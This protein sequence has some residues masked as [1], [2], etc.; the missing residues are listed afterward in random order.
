MRYIALI[1]L[2][3][4]SVAKAAPLLQNSDFASNA[5]IIS[6]GGTSS[7]LLNTAKIFDDVNS[8]LLDVT[9]AGLLKSP[10]NLV[11]QVNGVLRTVNGG[12][13][14][15]TTATNGQLLIGNGSGYTLATLIQGSGVTITNGAG[16]ITISASNASSGGTVT[17]VSVVN[18]GGISAVVTNPTTTPSI[19]LSASFSA[20]VVKASG[21]SFS[22]AVSG[23]DYQAPVTSGNGISVSGNTIS[24]VTPV[25]IAN[26]GTGSS[27]SPSNGQLLIGNGTG[28]TLA[29]LVQGSNVTITNNAGSITI[30][31]SNS[32]TS[33][34][35]SVVSKT[36]NYTMTNSD[37]VIIAVSPI[38]ITIQ[39]SASAT[40]KAYYLKNASSG[41]VT[42]LNSGADTTDGDTSTTLVSPNTAITIIPDGGT[43]WYIF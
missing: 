36:N 42:A 13:G 30:S 34:T 17:S 39:T 40:K 20:A 15:A 7:Q 9:I 23:V 24:L 16:S 2:L 28:Y 43:A 32:S 25:N 35:L 41:V 33:S 4:T 38:T 37:D 14:L 19:A 29:T 8:Q 31:A 3:V 6:A 12:T 1:L 5:Q 18:N 26:G 27:V 22:A 11:T 10:I 21:G